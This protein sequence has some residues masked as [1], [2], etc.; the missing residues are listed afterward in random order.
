[1]AKPVDFSPSQRRSQTTSWLDI[2]FKLTSKSS[3]ASKI[4][5]VGDSSHKL[6]KQVRLLLLSRT[7]KDGCSSWRTGGS[8]APSID[9]FT[10]MKRNL[11]VFVCTN[12]NTSYV[13][14]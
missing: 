14:T 9:K 4:Q 13:A 3:V 12:E 6:G 10:R 7:Q 11:N 5:L 1:M 8:R 2:G